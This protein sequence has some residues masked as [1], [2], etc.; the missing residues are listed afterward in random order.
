MVNPLVSVII[1]TYNCA[2]FLRE[3]LESVLA[4]TY[5]PL[6][7]LVI[8]DG[9]TDDPQA[10]LGP[11][12]WRVTFLTQDHRGAADHHAASGGLPVER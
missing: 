5:R 11:H 12:R 10:A 2:G 6:E 8:D 1:P 4:Q 3:A 7:I 9:S